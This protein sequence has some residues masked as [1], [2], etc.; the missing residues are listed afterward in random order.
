M[1]E[2]LYRFLESPFVFYRCF[3][4]SKCIVICLEESLREDMYIAETNISS[5]A[6]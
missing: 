2:E 1:V 4:R 6:R 5:R 3:C